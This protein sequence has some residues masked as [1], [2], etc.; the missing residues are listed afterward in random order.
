MHLLRYVLNTKLRTT[1][2]ILQNVLSL[3]LHD[4]AI[5]KQVPQVVKFS[6]AL[7]PW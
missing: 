2:L 1:G 6:P 7:D 3:S 4:I 5:P